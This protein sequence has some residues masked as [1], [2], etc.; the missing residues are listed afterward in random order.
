[1]TLFWVV[2]EVAL[3]CLMLASVAI[4]FTYTIQLVQ[5]NMFSTRCGRRKEA[6]GRGWGVKQQVRPSSGEG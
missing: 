5:D 2:W 3:S 6:K 1:M 4:R